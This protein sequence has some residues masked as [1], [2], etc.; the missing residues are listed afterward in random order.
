MA[1][2]RPQGSAYTTRIA[3]GRVW[4]EPFMAPDPLSFRPLP[5]LSINHVVRSPLSEVEDN[6]YWNPDR[7]PQARSLKTWRNHPQLSPVHPRKRPSA[8]TRPLRAIHALTFRSP[9]FVAVCVRRKSRKEV[10]HAL[11]KI[12]KGAGWKKKPR[13]SYWSNIRC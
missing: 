11:G 5:S 1:R 4:H 12:G 8:G 3:N 13:R 10:L 6:R 9:K 7:V 2:K